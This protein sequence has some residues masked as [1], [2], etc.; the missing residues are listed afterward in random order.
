MPEELRLA[1]IYHAM[2]STQMAFSWILSG[3]PAPEAELADLITRMRGIGMEHL[4]AGA[5]TPGNPYEL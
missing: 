4:F 1:T 3:F 5:Q 2:A